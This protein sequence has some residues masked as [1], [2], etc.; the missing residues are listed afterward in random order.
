MMDRK[1]DEAEPGNNVVASS[2]C[3]PT[4][5]AD[6]SDSLAPA[7]LSLPAE[8]WQRIVEYLLPSI[9][10]EDH[11]FPHPHC[12]SLHDHVPYRSRYKEDLF[13]LAAACRRLERLA[14][15]ALFRAIDLPATGQRNKFVDLVCRNDEG[16]MVPK[17]SQRAA[18]I[19]SLRVES[20]VV[21]DDDHHLGW[22]FCACDTHVLS[23]VATGL[24][25]LSLDCTDERARDYG[26]S[27]GDDN[28]TDLGP[29]CHP[30]PHFLA[31]STTCRPC[32]LRL[33]VRDFGGSE[34]ASITLR[35]V[36]SFAPLS[37]TTHLEI[38]HFLPQDD[39][40]AILVGDPQ[41]ARQSKKVREGISA[42]QSP[43]LKLEC[44]R[45]SCGD[46]DVLRGFDEYVAYRFAL[47]EYVRL[48]R[49]QQDAVPT[50]VEPDNAWLE[51]QKALYDL[52]AS[53]GRL[54]L[55]RL[56]ILEVCNNPNYLSAD[57][58]DNLARGNS[59]EDM[60]GKLPSQA[61]GTKG[62]ASS[63]V[64]SSFSQ[65]T[66]GGQMESLATGLQDGEP[67]DSKWQHQISWS[68]SY[69]RRVHEGKLALRRL[70]DGSRPQTVEG[71][72]PVSTEIRIVASRDSRY[73]S[74][75]GAED[76]TC[77]HP[78]S[79]AWFEDFYTSQ[80]G[81][82]RGTST[83]NAGIWAD[84]DIFSLVESRP[85]LPYRQLG[86][87]DCFYW[88]GELPRDSRPSA[89]VSKAGDLTE[90]TIVPPLVRLDQDTLNKLREEED[91]QRLERR[92]VPRTSA[93]A[94][95]SE[96]RQRIE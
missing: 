92:A 7:W 62:Y 88:T 82:T 87:F 96:K 70:W 65:A 16:Q 19:R 52:A 14:L 89:A 40:L 3:H 47:Q 79:R 32:S 30:L 84:P 43:R 95:S 69:W 17:E 29:V 56:L 11:I 85:W 61:T 90:R 28:F 71:A 39:L 35:G 73:Y 21:S 59:I 4:S 74:N 22:Y 42:G 20:K 91:G 60:T 58:I 26:Y 54:P 93:R 86:K 23:H 13:A 55:L 83:H 36:N 75:K 46:N 15:P 67:I 51:P 41:F 10:P 64:S 9:R 48:P 50:P 72:V 37:Q 66:R 33:S 8:I 38:A 68:D 6:R 27:D 18:W 45:L 81:Q 63:S 34:P 53:A 80:G 94:A 2:V 1:S 25:F 78:E 57:S 44:L 31:T 24:R 12:K 77:G 76:C 5:L 49:S